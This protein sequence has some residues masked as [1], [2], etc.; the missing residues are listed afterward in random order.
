[1]KSGGVGAES[2]KRATSHMKGGRGKE[3]GR[4]REGRKVR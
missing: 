2:R 4:R 3:E 1:M